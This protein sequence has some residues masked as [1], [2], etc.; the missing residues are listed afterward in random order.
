MPLW[1]GEIPDTIY[2]DFDGRGEL[3]TYNWNYENDNHWLFVFDKD[4]IL[5]NN[6]GRGTI[7]SVDMAQ[8]VCFDWKIPVGS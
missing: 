2:I 8:S 4:L 1:L 6:E 7:Y 5:D 3:Y